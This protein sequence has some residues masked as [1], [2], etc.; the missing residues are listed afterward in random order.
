ML[1]MGEIAKERRVDLWLDVVTE[2][3][4]LRLTYATDCLPAISGIA[5]RF[6]QGIDGPY[7]AGLWMADLIRCLTW[8][9]WFPYPQSTQRIQPYSAPTWSWA[10]INIWEVPK[11]QRRQLR[12]ISYRLVRT[13]GFISDPRV[14]PQTISYSLA[15]A[16]QFG[17]AS[18]AV[19]KIQGP[20][21]ITKRSRGVWYQQSGLVDDFDERE[22]HIIHFRGEEGTVNADITGERATWPQGLES[23]VAYCFLL[24]STAKK[25]QTL[26]NLRLW[27]NGQLGGQSVEVY[28]EEL[29][30]A[31]VLQSA[32]HNSALLERTGIIRLSKS[33]NWFRDAPLITAYIT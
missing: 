15:G 23:D 12:R 2:F 7:L 16:N 29:D 25:A 32:R 3:S 33:S 26:Q 21:I 1:C 20:C 30:I 24:G 6:A 22:V 19:L 9:L 11:A 5:S 18:K 14:R 13:H 31:L 17:Q 4:K 27:H 10:S 28:E 8:E